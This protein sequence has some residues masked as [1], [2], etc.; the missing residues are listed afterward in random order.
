[1][2]AGPQAGATDVAGVPWDV[3]CNQHH[4]TLQPE[5]FMKIFKYHIIQTSF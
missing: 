4:M 5:Y 1:M 3:R 2:S